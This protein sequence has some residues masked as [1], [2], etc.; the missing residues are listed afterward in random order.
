MKLSRLYTFVRLAE[1]KSFSL[2]AEELK[3]TQPAVSI[4]VK[5]LE[6]YFNVQLVER[7]SEGVTLTDEGHLLYR[8][9]REMLRIW[10]NLGRKI[11]DL[12]SVV[13][14]VITIGASTIPADYI[15]PGLIVNF[16]RAYPMVELKMEVGDSRSVVQD[17][18]KRR[19]DIGIVGTRPE[20][21]GIISFPVAY[22]ELMLVV[23]NDHPLSA[24]VRV[25]AG[26]IFEE[27]FIVREEGSGTRKA[28]R[29]GLRQIG[30]NL[31]DLK[32][33]AQL[34]S[35]EAVITAVEEGLGV[36]IVSS[37]PAK[38]AEKLQRLKIVELEGFHIQRQ[39]Y[40][41]YLAQ[42]QEQTLIR[43][44]VEYISKGQ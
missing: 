21:E 9:A 13:K 20:E 3:I 10:E 33:A 37:L 4:Q 31:N 27:R 16:S 39:F 40:L 15:L 2:V 42:A 24:K 30:L 19:Y 36:A 25:T 26:E 11:D 1:L 38:R 35:A 29:E 28:M 41:G 22:D 17:L 43:K 44:F 32:V 23:S 12:R 18:L 34:G 5:V 6:E 7:S 14:G 8:E